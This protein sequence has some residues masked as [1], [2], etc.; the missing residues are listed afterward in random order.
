[1][2]KVNRF[3]ID[4]LFGHKNFDLVFEDNTLVLVGENGMGKTTVLRLLYFY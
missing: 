3:K 2:G 4:K 1:M